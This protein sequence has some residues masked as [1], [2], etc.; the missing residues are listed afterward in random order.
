[1]N[2]QKIIEQLYRNEY[3]P[4]NTYF[5]GTEYE[6]PENPKNLY[7]PQEAIK[8]L[9]DAGW[10]DHDAQGRLVK[11]GKPL[12]LQVVYDIGNDKPLTVYQEDLRKVG[13]TLEFNAVSF[14]TGVQLVRRERQ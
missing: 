3:I 9:E 1:V 10:K 8:L 12:V 5:P 7:N 6:N 13:I 2:R 14:E 11:N 4:L